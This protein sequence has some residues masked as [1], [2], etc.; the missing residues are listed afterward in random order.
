MNA[1]V[2]ALFLPFFFKICFYKGTDIRVV[3]GCI[4]AS[5]SWGAYVCCVKFH[6][7][8]NVFFWFFEKSRVIASYTGR[9]KYKI[10]KWGSF[11]KCDSVVYVSL[12]RGWTSYLVLN[13][14]LMWMFYGIYHRGTTCFSFCLTLPTVTPIKSSETSLTLK[15][16]YLL[17]SCVNISTIK[18]S[19]T[20]FAR[21]IGS[22][23]DG[24]YVSGKT[25]F[26]GGGM[27]SHITV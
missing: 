7:P 9:L 14:V 19:S 22:I 10:S 12:S 1:I 5:V 11:R 8:L 4:L 2:A 25:W 16:A 13:L 15:F 6:F 26:S 23:M 3:V 21:H 18:C 17:V 20:E 24:F 27:W